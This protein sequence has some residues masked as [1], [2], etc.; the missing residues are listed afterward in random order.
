MGAESDKVLIL[1]VDD[2]D[3]NLFIFDELFREEL[4]V[5]TTTSVEEALKL[6]KDPQQK[7]R[8]LVT[9]LKMHPIGGMSFA[10][11]VRD[12]SIDIPIFILSAFPV[13]PEINDAIAKGSITAFF[14][15]PLEPELMLAEVKRL[16]GN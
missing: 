4:D 5:L 3:I 15:K 13:T 11:R 16:T 14:N 9:D 2:E 12:E 6:L 10:K 1:Y 8:L 7:I